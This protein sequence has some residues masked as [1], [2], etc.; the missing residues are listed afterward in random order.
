M[1]SLKCI[2]TRT[3]GKISEKSLITVGTSVNAIDGTAAIRKMPVPSFLI[4]WADFFRSLSPTKARLTS[5]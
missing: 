5:P 2:D 1:E 3:S 4:D